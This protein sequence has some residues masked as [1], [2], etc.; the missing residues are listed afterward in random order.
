MIY[1]DLTLQELQLE[2]GITSWE[3]VKKSKIDRKYLDENDS[4]ILGIGVVIL[5]YYIGYQDYYIFTKDGDSKKM[6]TI[7]YVEEDAI[8]EDKID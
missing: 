7:T 8:N 5:E 1:T 2:M 3:K 6:Y 4:I